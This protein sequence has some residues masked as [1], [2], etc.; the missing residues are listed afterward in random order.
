FELLSLARTRTGEELLAGWLT[1]P[2][3]PSEIQARQDAVEELSSALDLREQLA[4][5]GADVRA[6]VQTDRLLDW[7]ESPISSHRELRVFTWVF[8]AAVLLAIPYVAL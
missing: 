8:T 2:A 5:G 4:L 6:G 3:D 1:S 7:A